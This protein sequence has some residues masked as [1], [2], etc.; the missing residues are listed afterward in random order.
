MVNG[1]RARPLE[2][3]A[4]HSILRT[5]SR[6]GFRVHIPK[7]EACS[8]LKLR[9]QRRF[10]VDWLA[11]LGIAAPESFLRDLAAHDG[12]VLA[13]IPW[14]LETR[15]VLHQ[16]AEFR[17]GPS[18]FLSF[19]QAKSLE[20]LTL[21]SCELGER[22]CLGAGAEE[23]TAE[24]AHRLLLADLAAPVSMPALA[25]RVGVSVSRLQTAFRAR[26]GVSPY[27]YLRRARLEKARALLCESAKPIVDIVQ[28][29]GWNCPSRFGASFRERYG[30]TPAAWRKR[31]TR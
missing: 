18:A 17:Y 10:F 21:F 6:A 9:L 1:A 3:K 25:R 15:I 11:Q 8:F 2:L 24:L 28:E 19:L 30:M 14:T 31:A 22:L 26:Y 23:E 12:R 29:L 20:L 16:I 13:D 27:A 5:P 4:G 7:R